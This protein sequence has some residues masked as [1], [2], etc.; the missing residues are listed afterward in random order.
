M[1]C[2]SL[3]LAQPEA[4]QQRLI[5]DDETLVVA[6]EAGRGESL[7]R[8]VGRRGLVCGIDRFGASAPY[9]ALAEAFGFTPDAIAARVR[10]HLAGAGNGSIA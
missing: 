10:Q 3:F 2:T 9:T 1:P 4:Y 8:F 5:P 6:V 7:R